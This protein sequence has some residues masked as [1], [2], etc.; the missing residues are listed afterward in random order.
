[1]FYDPKGRK[2]SDSNK[3]NNANTSIFDLLRDKKKYDN[4]M[5]NCSGEEFTKFAVEWNGLQKKEDGDDVY[6]TKRCEMIRMDLKESGDAHVP[7]MDE[8]VV[9]W[10]REAFPTDTEMFSDLE[11]AGAT[12]GDVWNALKSKKDVYAAIG[13][14]DSIVRERVFEHLCELTGKKYDT[15]YNMWLRS[16]DESSYLHDF[17]PIDSAYLDGD[18][19]DF[20]LD[21]EDDLDEPIGRDPEFRGDRRF[22]WGCHDSF[23]TDESGWGVDKY[24]RDYCPNCAVEMGDK[25]VKLF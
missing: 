2:F 1:M 6:K 18:D 7:G 13:A 21:D 15:V 10:Y 25:I 17:K 11:A 4:T 19:P 3:L 5:S 9:D 24:N 20:Q 22:C 14:D 8:L 16:A 23:Y 12:F